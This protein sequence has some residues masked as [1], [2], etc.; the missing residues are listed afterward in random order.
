MAKIETPLTGGSYIRGKDGSL[1]RVA[2][3]EAS[4]PAEAAV[5]ASAPEPETAPAVAPTRKG[6]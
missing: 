5:P 3:T 6:K 4:A 1:T 2:G